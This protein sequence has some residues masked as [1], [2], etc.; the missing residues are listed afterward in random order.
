MN[1]PVVEVSPQHRIALDNCNDTPWAHRFQ[2]D[3]TSQ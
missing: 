2:C 1:S 3:W